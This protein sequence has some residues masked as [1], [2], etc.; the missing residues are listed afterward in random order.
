MPTIITNKLKLNNAK[1]FID[2]VSL[3]SGNSLYMFL[4]K[5]S[6]WNDDI[7]PEPTDVQE[8]NSKIWD[9]MISLKRILPSSIANVVKRIDWE[10]GEYY[11]E[12]N[13]EDPDLFSKNFYVLNSQFDVYKC[14]DNNFRAPSTISPTG[15]FV[16]IITLADGYR[17]KYMY[18]IS[19]GEQTKFLTR[20][21]MPVFKNTLVA[22][23]AK[24]GGIE[25]IKIFNGGADYSA[26]SNVNIIGDGQNA[27]IRPKINL[28]VI[29]DFVYENVGVNFRY[30]NAYIV[31]SQA[32]GKYANIKAIINP[33]GGHGFDP[34]S[35]LNANYVMIN[36]RTNYNE[37]Y[38][39]FPGGFTF[40]QLGII[41]NPVNRDGLVAANTTLNALTSINLSNV[42][43]TFSNNE[44]VEG[45]VSL[46]NVFLVT[47]NV[48]SGNGYG[49]Y[50]QSFG[51]TSNFTTFTKNE[52]I[53]GRTS[54]ATATVANVINSEVIP[55]RGDI[56]YIENRS[57]IT[58]SQSQTD[59]LHLVI[60]F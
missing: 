26:F 60:E 35:E 48:I 34:V 42:N 53:I 37:G 22:A 51:L 18:S 28:G 19:T 10:I 50:L 49:K 2:S 6:I 20:Y 13:P 36:V 57:P 9:E 58:R 47:S 12:Y 25:H 30:A 27:I 14:I 29:Y 32:S 5:P 33:Q 39:D 54:G 44:F 4:A 11:D 52:R 56:L 21:W 1:N 17:W 55:N 8:T 16:N 59:N 40:R 15:R 24:D 23:N 43:G 38:G 45:T 3:D 41:K 31:D 46:A 7:V